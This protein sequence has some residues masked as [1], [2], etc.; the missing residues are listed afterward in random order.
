MIGS[1][2]ICALSVLIP[3]SLSQIHGQGI[4]I[5]LEGVG[6]G[7][8]RRLPRQVAAGV[9]TGLDLTSPL[10]SIRVDAEVPLAW[11]ASWLAKLGVLRRGL[12]R[13]ELGYV[14]ALFRGRS[15]VRTRSNATGEQQTRPSPRKR[16][17]RQCWQVV[18]HDSARSD[19]APSNRLAMNH[20]TE[21]QALY[22]SDP[23]TA[24]APPPCRKSPAMLSA[25]RVAEALTESRSRCA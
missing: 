10:R 23:L 8:F 17:G 18:K 21:Q 4:I 16:S 9:R 14:G 6:D 25:T 24:A 22:R 7:G 20:R 13:V 15:T 2:S 12:S 1:P 11:P 3:V 19:A 5:G